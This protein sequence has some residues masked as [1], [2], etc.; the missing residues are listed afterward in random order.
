MA[1]LTNKA[2]F[3]QRLPRFACADVLVGVLLATR[4]G[5]YK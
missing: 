1:L 2:T 4:K 3:R 5:L